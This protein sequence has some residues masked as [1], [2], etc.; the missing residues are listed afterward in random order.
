MWKITVTC[1]FGCRA[2]LNRSKLCWSLRNLVERHQQLLAQVGLGMSHRCWAQWFLSHDP[3]DILESLA[4]VLP[5]L[6]G[7]AVWG[8]SRMGKRY[9]IVEQKGGCLYLSMK[10]SLW[11]ELLWNAKQN[12]FRTWW[13]TKNSVFGNTAIKQLLG[14]KYANSAK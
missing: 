6:Q 9:Q 13:N 5:V 14:S 7:V 2:C 11:F 8:S 1:L 10:S 12:T 4:E 3:G